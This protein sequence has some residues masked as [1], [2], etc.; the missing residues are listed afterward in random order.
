MLRKTCLVMAALHHSYKLEQT[1][2][3]P[4]TIPGQHTLNRRLVVY[5]LTRQLNGEGGR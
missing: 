4:C 1:L 5:F 3:L 2:V